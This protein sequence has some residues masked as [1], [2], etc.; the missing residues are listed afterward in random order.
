MRR[1][2]HFATL[3]LPLPVLTASS[4]ARAD[5]SPTPLGTPPPDGSAL[6]AAPTMKDAPKVDGAT[7][8]TTATV[9]AGAQ[10]TTG[11]TNMV[12][13]TANAKYETRH[14]A[15]GFGASILGNYGQSEPPDTN[16]GEHVTTQ[17]LQGRIR[18]DRYLSDR[19][20]L[21][22]IVTGRNDRFQGLIFRLNVDPGAKY[23]FVANTQTTLWGELGY[24]YQFD[25][26]LDSASI[27]LNPSLRRKVADHSARAFLGLKHAFNKDV[28]FAT[29]LEYLQGFVHSTRDNLNFDS[30][31]NFDA[32]L[33]ANLG[34]G[35]AL[36]VGFTAMWD[37]EPLPGKAHTDTTS[38]VSLIYSFASAAP[39]PAKTPT[40][41]PPPCVP[42]VPASAPGAATPAPST[43]PAPP[44]APATIPAPT[45]A[46]A[47]IA[48]P[49]A[50]APVPAPT[51]APATI[52]APTAAPATTPSP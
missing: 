41:A 2:A 36:G 43:M 28:T 39:P 23:L 25:Y 40:P 26:R 34:A 31:L 12:A 1:F 48:A 10:M 20:S 17:N 38:T 13:A 16:S 44:P 8:Q 19:F 15:D 9:S 30:R 11:N 21:F 22:A 35:L 4:M 33:A 47:T 5:S 50:S 52:P 45:A 46:P 6:V 24:D 42:P 49:A 14:G 29:G 27:D 3:L 18:Y 37:R 51:P 32:L 7:N